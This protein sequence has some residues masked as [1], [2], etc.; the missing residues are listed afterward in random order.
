[1]LAASRLE[2][3]VLQALPRIL[4]V[5]IFSAKWSLVQVFTVAWSFIQAALAWTKPGS[6]SFILSHL[7]ELGPAALHTQDRYQHIFALDGAC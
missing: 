4:A 3:C 7:A 5:C 1:M 6:P 2:K